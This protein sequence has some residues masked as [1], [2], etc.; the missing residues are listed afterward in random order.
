MTYGNVSGLEDPSDLLFTYFKSEDDEHCPRF[1]IIRDDETKSI[2]LAVRGTNS[3]TDV[4]IDLIC[5]E[6]VRVREIVI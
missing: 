5:D 6:E 2:V 3:F 4:I 1:A